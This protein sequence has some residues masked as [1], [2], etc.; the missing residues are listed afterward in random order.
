MLQESHE[1]SL[2]EAEEQLQKELSALSAQH[3]VALALVREEGVA[4]ASQLQHLTEERLHAEWTQKMNEC[5]GEWTERARKVTPL[6]L[7]LI[8]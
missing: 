1:D 5:D 2:A 6:G 3:E 4:H 7:I 8:H